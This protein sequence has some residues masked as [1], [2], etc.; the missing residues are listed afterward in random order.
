MH[1]EQQHVPKK[2]RVKRRTKCCPHKL[3]QY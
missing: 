1:D 3:Q 2:N